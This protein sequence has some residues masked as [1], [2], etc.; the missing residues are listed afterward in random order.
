VTAEPAPMPLAEAICRAAH[1]AE[2]QQVVHGA[3]RPGPRPGGACWTC[4]VAASVA[5]ERGAW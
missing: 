5:R 4:Q 3:L 2:W 1:E